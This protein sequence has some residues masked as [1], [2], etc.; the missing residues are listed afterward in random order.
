M[1]LL[2]IRTQT[3]RLVQYFWKRSIEDEVTKQI[4]LSISDVS[5]E[6]SSSTSRTQT[7]RFA[8][9]LEVIKGQGHEMDSP[10]ARR[11]AFQEDILRK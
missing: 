4:L 7:K 5:R 11:S 9:L 2:N 3:R 6:R 8:F 10:Q 1:V